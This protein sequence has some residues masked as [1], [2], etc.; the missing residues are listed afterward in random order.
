MDNLDIKIFS[1][2]LNNCRESDR[3]MGIELGMSGGAVR[4]RI[5]KMEERKIIENFFC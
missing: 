4:A 1:K 5:R 3:Q 2:L